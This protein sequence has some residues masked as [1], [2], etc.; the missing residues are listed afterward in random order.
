MLSLCH[1]PVVET[2]DANMPAISVSIEAAL[3]RGPS[4]AR[5]RDSRV[6]RR[7]TSSEYPSDSPEDVMCLVA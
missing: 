2:V 4:F 6:S 3:L 7:Q 5:K 1:R